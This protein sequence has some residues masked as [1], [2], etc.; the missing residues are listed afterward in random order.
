MIEKR[1]VFVAVCDDCKE[2]FD[3]IGEGY[4][5]YQ[6]ICDAWDAIENAEWGF[7]REKDSKT[8]CSDCADK[9]AEESKTQQ[10]TNK[11]CQHCP[12]VA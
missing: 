9:R 5:V 8:Y 11:V 12:G 1:E 10:P 7:V 2:I 3:G 4:S 6:N